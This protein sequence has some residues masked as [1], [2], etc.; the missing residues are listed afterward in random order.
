M[1]RGSNRSA[2]RGLWT[3]GRTKDLERRPK[4]GRYIDLKSGLG[5]P[6]LLSIGGALLLDVDLD[7]L[8]LDV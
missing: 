1:A 2:D 6:I 8:A 4:D 3:K 5:S 7:A